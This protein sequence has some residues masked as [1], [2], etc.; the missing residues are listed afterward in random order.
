LL[1]DFADLTGWIS[2][3]RL[4]EAVAGHDRG[5]CRGCSGE[6]PPR[7]PSRGPWRLPLSR[8]DARSCDGDSQ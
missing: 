2:A 6:T 1:E 3:A 7:S 8:Q 5:G 4:L